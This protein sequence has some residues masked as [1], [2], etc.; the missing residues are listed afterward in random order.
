L[1]K[2]TLFAVLPIAAVALSVFLFLRRQSAG[3]AVNM[4]PSAAAGEMLAEQAVRLLG[5]KG[6]IVVVARFAAKEALGVDAEQLAAF[7]GAIKRQNGVSII[8]TEWLAQPQAG[9]MDFGR[10]TAEQLFDWSQKHPEATGLVVFAGLPEFSASL[11]GKL[12]ERPIKLLAVCGYGPY[13]RQWLEAQA[14]AAVVVPRFGALPS[15]TPAPKT[16]Q[17]WFQQE[18][19]LF[20]PESVGRLPY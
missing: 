8:G 17:D 3:S 18:Y 7:T 20:T 6:K 16:T 5:G 19:E 1:N 13:I 2:K 9:T 14:L 10:V 4:R 11:A 12:A 15:G